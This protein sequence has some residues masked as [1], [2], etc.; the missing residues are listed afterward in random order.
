MYI[1]PLCVLFVFLL[2]SDVLR[3]LVVAARD[4]L[5][6]P[7]SCSA[8]LAASGWLME[9]NIFT[10]WL[11]RARR[12]ACKNAILIVEFAK[13]IQDEIKKDR[14]PPPLKA[15]RLRFARSDDVICLF[16]VSFRCP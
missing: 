10:R 16:S 4:H 6:V 5:I 7:M 9:N 12:P 8:R 11:C 3:K 15:G 13:Q 1:F 14:F 2:L